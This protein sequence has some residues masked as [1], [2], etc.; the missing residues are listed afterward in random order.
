MA[1]SDEY[2]TP[3]RV[4]EQIEH[5]QQS[6]TL[7]EVTDETHLV[8]TL[9][10]SYHVPLDAEDR[11]ALA[12]VRQRVLSKQS[13]EGIFADAVPVTTPPSLGPV[14][15]PR[16]RRLPQIL[17]SLAA[18]ILVG[19]LLGSW[20]AVTHM[21]SKSLP[22]A[23]NNSGDLYVVQSGVAYGFDGRSGKVLWQNH[24]STNEQPGS[25]DLRVVNGVAYVM[26]NADIYALDARNGKQIWHVKNP[27]GKDYFWYV[28]DDGRVYLFSLDDTF[29]ALNATDGSQLWHN[30]SFT[31]ENGY[32]FSVLDGNLY[33]RNSG[34]GGINDQKLYSLD[35]TTGQVRWNIS[36]QQGSLTGSPLVENGVVY[37][38]AGN[39]FYA[40]KEQSGK[41]IWEQTIPG[42]GFNLSLVNDILYV[43]NPAVVAYVATPY[44]G[45]IGNI[46]A[47]DARTGQKLWISDA[48]YSTLDAPITEGLLLA[49]RL[50]NGTSS[51]V[52]L[53]PQT[54]SVTWQVLLQEP[55]VN[56]G[57]YSTCSSGWTKVI[58]GELYLLEPSTS[59]SVCTLKSF[60]P[61]NG[62][63]LSN[64]SLAVKQGSAS[65][66]GASNG[67]LYIQISVP[68]T[69]NGLP[70]ADILFAA[71]RLDDGS[72]VW[73]HA[74][75]P[76]PP[77]TSA[78]TTPNTSQPVLA[79]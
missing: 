16:S 58:D 64:Q 56:S 70:Y 17:S 41:R 19:A 66:I 75:P 30:T 65:G 25:A 40:V 77:P 62:Q 15:R 57:G 69:A 24:L 42:G 18:V 39:L 14:T 59:Q 13:E 1:P 35:G 11:A 74:M 47:L 49:K 72:L 78:N 4:D 43:N 33:T 2:F 6:G 48:G 55:P 79:P 67:R 8:N 28:I 34:T 71:Y 10:Q 20:F 12:H 7:D 22:I 50:H 76:F 46:F 23:S 63:L 52:G 29:S 32:G 73:S 36:L 27:D 68:K 51:I 45:D 60:N 54:G 3:E 44:G 31:T 37:L 61:A 53:N 9:R 26:L 21:I 5:L 38:S